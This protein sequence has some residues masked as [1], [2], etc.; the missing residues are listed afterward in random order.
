M[1]NGERIQMKDIGCV[2]Q[3]DYISADYCFL[4]HMDMIIWFQWIFS[5][6]EDFEKYC[7]QI[8][9]GN[10]DKSVELAEVWNIFMTIIKNKVIAATG[11]F[12]YGDG[13][14]CNPSS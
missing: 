13:T 8:E 1:K 6:T 14:P 9:M 3:K 2:R 10:F 11:L 5:S 4:W 12:Y 7:L